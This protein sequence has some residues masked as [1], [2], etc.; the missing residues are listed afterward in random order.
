MRIAIVS[1]YSW[2]YAGGVNRHV[3]SLA[4]ELSGKRF[5]WAVADVTDRAA[6]ITA[7]TQ[8]QEQLGPV[9]LLIANAGMASATA[10]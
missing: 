7:A 5:A 10:A 4:K 1:P 8:L 2:T 9:D 6:L 3:E